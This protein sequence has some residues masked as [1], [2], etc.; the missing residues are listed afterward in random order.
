MTMMTFAA[1]GPLSA[2]DRVAFERIFADIYAELPELGQRAVDVLRAHAV[3]YVRGVEDATG[4][5]EIRQPG[6]F[7]LMYGIHAA[8]FA[9]GRRDTRLTVAEAWRS[10]ARHARI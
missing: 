3:G 6:D 1:Y 10:W 4:R 5:H 9:A 8:E 7:G 2:E